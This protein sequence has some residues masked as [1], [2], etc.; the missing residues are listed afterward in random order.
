MMSIVHN[1]LF[2][3]NIILVFVYQ[4]VSQSVCQSVKTIIYVLQA[5]QWLILAETRL[6]V[7]IDCEHCC[8]VQL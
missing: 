3:M 2:V 7:H 4:T 1:L 8:A 6:S 5:N